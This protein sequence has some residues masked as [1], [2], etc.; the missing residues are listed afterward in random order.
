M[1]YRKLGN[2]GLLVSELCLGTQTFGGVGAW[3][4]FGR[5]DQSEADRLVAQAFDAGINFFDTAEAYSDG[6]AEILLGKALGS[7]RG[8]AVIATKISGR[9]GPGLN[10]VGL[11]RKRVVAAVDASLTRLGTDYIDLYQLHSPDAVT[12]LEETLRALDDLVRAGKI[13]YVGCSNYPAWEVMK[14][15][16]ISERD[17]VARFA[18]LQAYYSLVGR[19][20]ERE[21]LSLLLDQQ[22]ALLVWSPLAGGLLT[23]K[24]AGGPGP[25]TARRSKIDFPPVDK[26]HATRCVT[27]AQ[28]IARQHHATV[29][30]IALA[31]LLHQEAV[32]SVVIGATTSEQLADNLKSVDVRLTAGELQCLDQISALPSWYPGWI[33]DLASHEALSLDEA[34]GRRAR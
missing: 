12:P 24:F 20:V 31:W 32:T 6:T 8:D 26:A 14:G 28:G 18:S 4:T 19:D 15:I 34:R 9:F 5:Q 29:A 22:L 27:A 25:P 33:L 23:D 1:D 7:R 30:R 3:Q 11:S 17:Q 21:T 13:R 16:A 10:D 2:S